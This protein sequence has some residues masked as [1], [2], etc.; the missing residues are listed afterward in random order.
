MQRLTMNFFYVDT[1][2]AVFVRLVCD[3]NFHWILS[4]SHVFSMFGSLCNYLFFSLIL[5]P[6]LLCI[7]TLKAGWEWNAKK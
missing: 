3:S 6:L 4:E 1:L 2:R 5:A 7:G